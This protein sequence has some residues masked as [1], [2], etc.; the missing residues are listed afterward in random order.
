MSGSSLETYRFQ[1]LL[2]YKAKAGLLAVFSAILFVAES[3]ISP[4]YAADPAKLSDIQFVIQNI[5]GLLTPFAAIALLIMMVVGAFKFITSGGD[6]KAVAG[7]RGTL[8]YAI[9]GV[10]LLVASYLILKLIGTLTGAST[11]VVTFPGAP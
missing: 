8:T 9:L 11:T 5:I 6:P 4:V 2:T 10:I 3:V 1:W 7:A